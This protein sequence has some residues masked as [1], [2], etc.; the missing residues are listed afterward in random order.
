MHLFRRNIN[1]NVILFN[2]RIYGLTKG[3]YSPT[4]EFG[5]VT[6]STP[7]GSLDQPINPVELALT[8]GATFVARTIDREPPHMV[9][10]FKQAAA[11]KGTSFVEVYQNCNIFNDGA[12]AHLTDKAV[13]D[14][15][16]LYLENDQPL[17]FNKDKGI[18]VEGKD[19]KIID[20]NHNNSSAE[21]SIFNENE[22]TPYIAGILAKMTYDPELP[23]PVGVFRKVTSATYEDLLSDQIRSEVE[24]KGAGNLKDLFYTGDI[25]KV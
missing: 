1:I 16:L 12:F 22:A 14:G 24:Q 13:K 23:T 9:E 10:I 5:K 11:H 19:V 25:W 3:Q 21:L 7:Q 2:N 20:L 18:S 6:K 15:N 8:A 17:K 4:S